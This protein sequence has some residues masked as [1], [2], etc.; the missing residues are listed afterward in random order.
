MDIGDYIAI[1]SITVSAIIAIVGGTYTVVTS[2]KKFELSQSYSSEIIVW[3]EKVVKI[4]IRIKE[5]IYTENY[6]RKRDMT[7]LSA[8]IEVGRFYF[9]NIDFKDR[10]GE[11][12]PLAY[13]GYR[14]KTLQLLVEVYEVLFNER[15]SSDYIEFYVSQNEREFTSCVFEMLDPNKK[16]KLLKKYADITLNNNIGEE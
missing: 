15:N 4:L 6:D 10:Y 7:E 16:K 8:L 13:R 14:H 1:I 2:T 5:Y 9:P 3:Y 11:S 12:N